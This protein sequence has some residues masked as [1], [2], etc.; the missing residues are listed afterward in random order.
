MSASMPLSNLPPRAGEWRVA[1]E[2]EKLAVTKRDHI[3]LP[4]FLTVLDVFKERLAV[5]PLVLVGDNLAL[6]VC[7]RRELL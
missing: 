3:P 5:H 7:H 6:V 2:N 4:L 1:K